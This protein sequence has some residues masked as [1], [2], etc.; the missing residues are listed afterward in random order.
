MIQEQQ[1]DTNKVS[2]FFFVSYIRP[3]FHLQVA[4]LLRPELAKL[5]PPLQPSLPAAAAEMAILQHAA[6]TKTSNSHHIGS[7]CTGKPTLLTTAEKK[8]KLAAEN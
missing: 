1:Q 7:T 8:H 3:G 6:T 4:S 2:L 5:P